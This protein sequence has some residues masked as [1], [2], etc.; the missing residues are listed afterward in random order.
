MDEN[1]AVLRIDPQYG[2]GDN[3]SLSLDDLGKNFALAHAVTYYKAQGRTIR[4]QKV[5]LWD[6]LTARHELHEHVRL[7]HFIMGVQRVTDPAALRRFPGAAPHLLARP[8]AE[9][10][11]RGS[12][13]HRSPV[14]KS[15]GYSI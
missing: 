6:L 8:E 1:E 10:R 12:R 13:P 14:K 2:E 11:R 7:W 15:D 3:F 4:D 5:V 9:G